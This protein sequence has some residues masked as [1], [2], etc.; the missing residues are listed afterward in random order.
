MSDSP[1]PRGS[2][3]TVMH[4]GG[5]APAASASPRGVGGVG[6]GGGGR[7]APVAG[8][9]PWQLRPLPV[10]CHRCALPPCPPLAGVPLRAP[11]AGRQPP[12]PPRVC[13]LGRGSGGLGCRAPRVLL[14]GCCCHRGPPAPEGA[15]R[16]PVEGRGVRRRVPRCVA[17]PQDRNP[18]GA[19]FACCRPVRGGVSRGPSSGQASWRSCPRA[20]YGNVLRVCE[21][22]PPWEMLP[23]NHEK[24]LSFSH[25]YLHRSGGIPL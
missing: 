23:K 12:P 11:T 15:P 22:W 20:S 7:P 3:S 1:S 14:P 18:A 9:P 21:K 16:A 5:G 4:R 2:R 19:R 17:A 24:C 6:V 13:H 10:G 8:R 25:L